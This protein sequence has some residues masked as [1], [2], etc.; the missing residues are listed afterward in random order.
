VAKKGLTRQRVENVL[1]ARGQ[2]HGVAARVALHALGLARGAA[3]VERV[4]RV[5]GLDPDAGHAGVQVLRA[6]VGPVMV[7]PWLALH[8]H[9]AAI[10]EQ[11]GSRFVAR[12]RDGLV[13]QGLVGHDLAAART[14]VRADHEHG[15][16][17]LYARG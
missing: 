7:A 15:L 1:H 4:A 6:Q 5:R 13:E 17:I 10:D 12:L 8:G 14:R 2:R 9:K 11:H 3:G 16:G